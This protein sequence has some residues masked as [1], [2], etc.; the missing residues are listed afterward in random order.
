MRRRTCLSLAALSL[1]VAACGPRGSDQAAPPAAGTAATAGQAAVSGNTIAAIAAGSKDHSTLVAALNAVNLLDALAT[2]GPLTVFAPV[3]AAF[4]KLPPGT[5]E[6]LL[7]PEN[8][9]QLRTILQHHVAVSTYQPADLTSG[10]SL[11]MLDGGPTTITRQG[12]EITVDGAKVIAVV[13]AGNGMVYVVDAVLLP[14][15]TQ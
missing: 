6:N 8:A 14:K 2:P 15:P 12:D 9:A 11:S 4:D 3:N 13:P 7:K 1:F 5:V 10:L